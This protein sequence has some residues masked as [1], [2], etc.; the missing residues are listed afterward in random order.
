MEIIEKLQNGPIAASIDGDSMRYYAPKSDIIR[1]TRQK[2][3][4]HAVLIV[5]YTPTYWII[6][7][8]WGTSFGKDGFANVSRLRN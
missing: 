2:D 4:N 8:S 3:V 1:C 6:K 5:G 7:N